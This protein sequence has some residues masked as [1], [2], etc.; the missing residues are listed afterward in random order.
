MKSL[1]VLSSPW[2]QITKACR[3]WMFSSEGDYRQV[4]NVPILQKHGHGLTRNSAV[5][6][7]STSKN[8]ASIFY[9]KENSPVATQKNGEK[10]KSLFQM[11]LRSGYIRKF[12]RQSTRQKHY[13]E[14]T[15]EQTRKR[16]V[17]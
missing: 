6:T 8:D 7:E 13:K 10:E 4:G 5:I 16:A 1:G 12:I 14:T 9:S 2:G 15:T 17:F 11:F 3:F